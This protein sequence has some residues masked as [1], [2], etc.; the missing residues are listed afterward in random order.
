MY[1]TENINIAGKA[2]I[3]NQDAF[4]KLEKYL[5][6]LKN[7]F[8]N[9]DEKEIIE[10]IEF[11]IAEILQTELETKR[12]D[13]VSLSMIEDVI[14]TLGSP[15]DFGINENTDEPEPSNNQENV[16][17]KFFRDTDN[18]A[19]GGVCMGLANY[20]GI[21]ATWIRLAFF[22]TMVFGGS[23][24]FL[25]IILWIITPEAKTTAEKL[26]MKGK[27]ADISN[28]EERI[29]E[30]ASRVNDSIN[31]AASKFDKD[32]LKKTRKATETVGHSVANLIK[33]VLKIVGVAMVFFAVIAFVSL[34]S[35]FLS[36]PTTWTIDTLDHNWEGGKL[37]LF[38][39]QVIENP[40]LIEW[41]YLGV[42]CIVFTPVFILFFTGMKLAFN[43]KDKLKYMAIGIFIMFLT[44]AGTLAYCGIHISKQFT[45]HYNFET[46]TLLKPSLNYSIG[47][48]DDQFPEHFDTPFFNPFKVDYQED[49]IYYGNSRMKV[50]SSEG[51]SSYIITSHSSNGNTLR[52]SEA[53]SK[54]IKYSLEVDS[55]V[56]KLS[57]GFTTP[58]QDP[59]RGQTLGYFLYLA[60]GSSVTF[61]HNGNRLFYDIE[62]KDDIYD[63]YMFGK[64]YI[65]K[66]GQLS[67]KN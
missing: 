1:K 19:V 2:F 14:S 48:E 63:G 55:N 65:M 18:A 39:E 29:R 27:K 7:H 4:Q 45:A 38:I 52:T 66:D 57:P 24:F 59:Y 15:K 36:E 58:K 42:A 43:I 22:F 49:K 5:N 44:G 28:I 67:Q 62:N 50:F 9:E 41:F 60:E 46:T 16:K 31:K 37:F 8:S 54:R 10:D 26:Q 30:E 35:V 6:Q 32:V 40:E 53:L 20:W 56:I 3:I 17:K 13:V 21:D 34:L 64:T 11:R 61:P 12:V 47:L 25:Y 23:S 51:D 33:K